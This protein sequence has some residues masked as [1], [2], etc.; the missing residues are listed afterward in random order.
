MARENPTAGR[1]RSRSPS[2][3]SR[4]PGTPPA[5]RPRM[6]TA[7]GGATKES[8]LPSL[9]FPDI[10]HEA[11]VDELLRVS[12]DDGGRDVRLLDLLKVEADRA[13]GARRREQ[14]PVRVRLRL[15]R[16]GG[17]GRQG[18]SDVAGRVDEPPREDGPVLS[19]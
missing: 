18:I 15:F 9:F 19:S 3:S 14:V 6:P 2:G 8:R 10:P 12:R 16:M 1:D 11:L 17:A 13:V 7:P 5:T 4:W